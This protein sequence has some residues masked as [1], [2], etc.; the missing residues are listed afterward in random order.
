MLNRLHIIPPEALKTFRVKSTK[1][2][3]S[4]GRRPI[5]VERSF[6][7]LSI[8]VFARCRRGLDLSRKESELR[9]SVR[10]P[11]SEAVLAITDQ[12]TYGFTQA[13]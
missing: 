10:P 7:A 2:L 1:L 6:E 13:T 8:S 12:S 11:L 9:L 5:A 4:Y 3:V